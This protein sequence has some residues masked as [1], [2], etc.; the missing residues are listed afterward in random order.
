MERVRLLEY[1]EAQLTLPLRPKTARVK[2]ED[3][4]TWVPLE[5]AQA[6]FMLDE[7]IYGAAAGGGKS[8]TR[9]TIA[10]FGDPAVPSMTDGK[11]PEVIVT[12]D[13]LPG[14]AVKSTEEPHAPLVVDMAAYFKKDLTR[15]FNL[16]S[17]GDPV[18]FG[19]YQT[20]A[21]GVVAA[22][23]ESWR[24]YF[25]GHEWSRACKSAQEAE[26]EAH[27]VKLFSGPMYW[28]GLKRNL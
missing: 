17:D 23:P 11:L 4:P 9:K 5:G 26:L 13:R 18:H 1:G 7:K 16:G 12:I 28:R 25:G 10:A 15:W 27:A 21:N 20:S 24:K 19:V 2:L 14:P 8:V 22:Y 6:E 3:A